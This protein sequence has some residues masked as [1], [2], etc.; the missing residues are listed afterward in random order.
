MRAWRP[1]LLLVPVLALALALGASGGGD[2][3][4]P[5]ARS[6]RI[7]EKVRCPTCEGLSAAESDAAA[8]L[9][10]RKEIRQRVDRGET[11]GEILAFLVSRYGKDVLLEPEGSGV[12]GLVWALPVAVGLCAVAGLAFAFRQWSRRP[13]PVVVTAEDRRRVEEALA[14]SR[15]GDR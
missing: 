2:S 15:R 11:E 8:S 9:A 13:A 4:T 3:D 5:A 6:D 7:A 14:A 1:Y 10:I 12:A